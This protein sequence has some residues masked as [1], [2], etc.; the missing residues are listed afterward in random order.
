M[1]W[2]WWDQE[3]IDLEEAKGRAAEELDGKEKK[4][5]EGLAQE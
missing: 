2:R 3:V 4:C 5:I 1:S